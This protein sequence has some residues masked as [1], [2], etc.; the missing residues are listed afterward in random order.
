VLARDPAFEAGES[1][2]A[3]LLFGV[4]FAG[5][6]WL[7]TR[8]IVPPAMP[9]R[10]PG[11]EMGAVAL[12][13]LF[14]AVVVLGWLF[15]VVR[16]AVTDGKAEELAMLAIKLL[17]MVAL[18]G[19]L[20]T[21]LGYSWRE[22]LSLRPFDRRLWRVLLVMAPLL[23]ALQLVAGQGPKRLAA[24]DQPAWVIAVCAP[25]AL[26]WITIE[27]G[28]TEE[29]LFRL[30]LQTRAGAWLKSET[31]G[32]VAMGLLFAVAH[33]PGI[34]MRGAHAM[35]GMSAAPGM[36]TAIAYTIAVV[37]PVGIMFGVLWARTSSL[38]L[39]VLLHGWT[40][41]VPNLAPFVTTWAG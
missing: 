30:L 39:L 20:F 40:D 21:R 13:L 24:L 6:A 8:G 3:L 31:A 16:D 36:L 34:V 18:P 14:F 35:E 32:V 37:S 15:G 27:A 26:V 9:V 33:A 10:A 4:L 11:K 1:V 19:W 5:V 22:L 17:T 29:F 38:P 7:A 2:G 12:Y 25:L 23:L 28:L 41:L